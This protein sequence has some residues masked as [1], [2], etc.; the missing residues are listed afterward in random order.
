MGVFKNQ[1]ML[2]FPLPF[3][4]DLPK[5]ELITFA[6]QCSKNV[7]K[8]YKL[9]L[10]CQNQHFISSFL[11]EIFIQ[12]YYFYQ[13]LCKKTKVGVFSVHSL[14][15]NKQCIPSSLDFFFISAADFKFW[16][17]SFS[18]RFENG[19]LELGHTFPFGFVN[20]I[21]CCEFERPGCRC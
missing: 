10:C 19:G 8:E 18:L 3:L 21:V 2:H 17:F 9:F 12:I 13:E 14:L 7:Y 6:K 1:C 11:S 20:G 4:P 5:F 15:M 16:M